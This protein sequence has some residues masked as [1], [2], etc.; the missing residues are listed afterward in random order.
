MACFSPKI[1]ATEWAA[2]GIAI[3]S[4]LVFRAALGGKV[5]TG[6]PRR[7][8]GQNMYSSELLNGSPNR[9]V[10]VTKKP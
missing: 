7:E 6:P 5:V 2:P 4:G 9:L 8:V 3:N 1:L 10:K